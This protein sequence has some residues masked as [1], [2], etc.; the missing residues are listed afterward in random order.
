MGSMAKSAGVLSY[1]ALGAPAC[2]QHPLPA[3]RE[4]RDGIVQCYNVVVPSPERGH[5]QIFS[6]RAEQD[7]AVQLAPILLPFVGA[8]ACRQKLPYVHRQAGGHD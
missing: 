7:G 6:S 3:L 5:E 4:G 2:P 1:L 8:N